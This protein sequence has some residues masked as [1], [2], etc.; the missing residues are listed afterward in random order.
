MDTFKKL[1]ME[2]EKVRMQGLKGEKLDF[3]N[4]REAAKEHSEQTGAQLDYN[5]T[6]LELWRSVTEYLR[7]ILFQSK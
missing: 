1:E 2:H 3:S 5:G 6:N 7:E 4:L